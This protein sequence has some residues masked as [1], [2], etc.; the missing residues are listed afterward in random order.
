M[1]HIPVTF[2]EAE[3]KDELT[4]MGFK[5]S[6]VTRVWNKQKAA[7]PVV[8]IYLHSHEP[9]NKDIYNLERF[10]NCIVQIQP[11]KRSVHISQCYNCQRYGHTKNYCKLVAKCL[12]CAGPHKADV[13]PNKSQ[14]AVCA[15]CKEQHA[16]NFKGCK[17]YEDL[18][19]RR[20]FDSRPAV[21]ATRAEQP[22]PQSSPVPEPPPPIDN[23]YTFPN[24][25]SSTRSTAAPQTNNNN[26]HSY[27]R[28]FQPTDSSSNHNIIEDICLQIIQPLVLNIINGLRP[29]IADIVSRHLNGPK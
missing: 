2:E 9:K 12:F 8:F 26:E 27:A 23:L 10:L 24:L 29:M 14:D 22:E 11:K 20:F 15:N 18:Q 1:K 7:I 17:Y 28:L 3:I 5:I 4:N 16:A 6:N 19:K 13:C 21:N 25:S